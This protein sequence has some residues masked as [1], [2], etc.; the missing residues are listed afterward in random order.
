[1]HS[2]GGASLSGCSEEQGL[3]ARLCTR[4]I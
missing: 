1:L 3:G 2:P 4:F